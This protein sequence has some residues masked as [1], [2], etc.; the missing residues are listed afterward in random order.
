M[1]KAGRSHD[2]VLRHTDGSSNEVGINLY[3]ESPALKGGYSSEVVP[4]HP[5]GNSTNATQQNSYDDVSPNLDLVYEQTSWHRGVGQA[6]VQRRGI[7]DFRYASGDGVLSFF[8]G[9]R[10]KSQVLR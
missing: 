2:I 10:T 6:A 7:D 4:L 1:P 9:S 5:D 3:K 8:E